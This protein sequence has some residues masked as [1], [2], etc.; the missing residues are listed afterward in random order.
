MC[1]KSIVMILVGNKIDLFNKRVVS[2]SE[3]ETLA[4]DNNMLFIETSALSGYNI[5]ELFFNA[6]KEVKDRLENGYIELRDES[7]GIRIG[8]KNSYNKLDK[9]A[10]KKKKMCCKS[11]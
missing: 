10:D 7:C 5:D 4:H 9:G 3:G 1:P 11:N 8:K 6:S 2:T